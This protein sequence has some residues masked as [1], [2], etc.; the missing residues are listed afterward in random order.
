MDPLERTSSKESAAS[1][2]LRPSPHNLSSASSISSRKARSEVETSSGNVERASLSMPPPATKPVARQFP[3]GRPRKGSDGQ[4]VTPPES[5]KDKAGKATSS[6]IDEEDVRPASDGI[7]NAPQDPLSKPHAALHSAKAMEHEPD[8]KRASI[9]SLYSIGSAIYNGARGI[10]G[11]YA[12]SIAESEPY[13]SEAF[14]SSCAHP[15]NKL[16]EQSAQTAPPMAPPRPSPPSQS[17]RRASIR[18]LVPRLHSCFPPRNSA[19]ACQMC[20]RPPQTAP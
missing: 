7:D 16:R 3:A 12:G 8:P 1:A 13:G 18:C 19:P 17:P 15:S 2:Q 6:T 5:L 4:L 10:A 14:P 20:L 11:S 9:S